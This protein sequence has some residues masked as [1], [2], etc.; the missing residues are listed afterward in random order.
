MD[1]EVMVHAVQARL[2][3][4][5]TR[6]SMNEPACYTTSFIHLPYLRSQGHAKGPS[7]DSICLPL[8]HAVGCRVIGRPKPRDPMGCSFV[9]G[10]LKWEVGGGPF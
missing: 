2:A 9:V 6:P 4:Y 7:L 5:M 3:S 1:G 8:Q 10:F